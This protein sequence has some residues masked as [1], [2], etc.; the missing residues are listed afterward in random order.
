MN[1]GRHVCLDQDDI[2]K[3]ILDFKSC[4]RQLAICGWEVQTLMAPVTHCGLVVNLQS[5]KTHMTSEASMKGLS[6][7]EG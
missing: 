5:N 2:P 6:T 4:L 1:F 7:G 3:I